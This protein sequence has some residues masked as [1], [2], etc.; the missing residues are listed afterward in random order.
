VAVTL[1][2]S[3]AAA[4]PAAP[5]GLRIV[6]LVLLGALGVLLGVVGTLGWREKL[7][8]AGRL[9]VRTPDAVTTEATF[10]LA[11]RVAGPPVVVAGVAA[12]LGAV[13][14]FGLPTTT[15]TVVAAVIGLVGAL[16]IARAGGVLGTRA[17]AGLL[18]S[19]PA[20]ATVPPQC[21]GCV[22]GSGCSVL[23][24]AQPAQG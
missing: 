24:K 9:G 15:G 3:L 10:R 22:C 2:D 11:N 5:L 19:Q 6:L 21:A 14:A 18:A 4:S 20:E 7:S 1:A 8:K 13:A 23:T 12:V 16:L 17:A